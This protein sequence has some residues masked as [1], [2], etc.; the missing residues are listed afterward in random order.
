VG[1][2][3]CLSGGQDRTIRLWNPATGNEIKAYKGHGYEVLSIA[4]CVQG[5]HLRMSGLDPDDLLPF[6]CATRFSSASNGIQ[7]AR[8]LPVR[9]VWWGQGC[10]P[11]GR[12]LWVGHQTIQW[13][14]WQGERGRLQ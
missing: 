12:D 6:L 10:L 8:Q 11:V 7:H 14:L 4:V 2:K 1:A 13:A 3:Y 9:L 5:G